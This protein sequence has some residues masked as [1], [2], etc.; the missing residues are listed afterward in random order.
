MARI[1]IFCCT[2]DEVTA[3]YY[4]F[5]QKLGPGFTEPPGAPDLAQFR[6]VDMY[7]HCTCQSVK[8]TILAQF[9]VSSPLRIVVATVAFGMGVDC[10]DVRQVIHWGVPEDAETYVQETGRAGRDG[11]LSCAML[12]YCKKDLGKKRTSELMRT[13]CM[14]KDKICR[15]LVLFSDFDGCPTTA[16]GNCQCC[17]MCKQNCICGN[18]EDNLKIFI[19]AKNLI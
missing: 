1:I 9:T 5:R 3:I 19:V 12:F 7:T 6:L 2:Y 10:P 8:D 18:C 11:K 17:D 13:Y 15:K 4:Y 16:K 14:N